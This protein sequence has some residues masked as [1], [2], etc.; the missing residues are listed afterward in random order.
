MCF[1]MHICEVTE[2]YKAPGAYKKK[3]GESG[4]VIAM[5]D[6]LFGDPNKESEEDLDTEINS[7]NAEDGALN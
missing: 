6:L 3:S 2:C 1:I 7:L 4:G 5:I